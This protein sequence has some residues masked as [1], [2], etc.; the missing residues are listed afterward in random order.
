MYALLYCA[1]PYCV[2]PYC[3]RLTPTVAC[4]PTTCQPG[5]N[6]QACACDACFQPGHNLLVCVCVCVRSLQ[7]AA[8]DGPAAWA[9][10][11]CVCVC[12][13]SLQNAAPDGPA[14]WVLAE[15]IDRLLRWL[16]DDFKITSDL[17]LSTA[18]NYNDQVSGEGGG[19][20]G[21][22]QLRLG[23]GGSRCGRGG[24]SEGGRGGGSGGGNL[25]ARCSASSS[26]WMLQSRL[27]VSVASGA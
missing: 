17:G 5:N 24:C 12:V 7:N 23:E 11:P 3:T 21:C 26:S 2:L 18:C 15:V 13:P 20:G 16:D 6:V 25:F 10:P 9:Q 22:G 4:Q 14:A 8:P 19:G 1:L 27:W